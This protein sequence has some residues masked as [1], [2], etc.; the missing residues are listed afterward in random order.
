MDNTM[1]KS[2]GGCSCGSG[3]CTPDVNQENQQVKVQGNKLKKKIVIDFLY[4]D[5]TV[6]ERCQGTENNLDNSVDEVSDVLKS[7]GFGVVVNKI[8]V[9]TKELA[10]KHRFLSSPTIRVNGKDIALELKES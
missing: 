8:N 5:L 3:C 10:I 9:T 4:L 1:G 7:A 2:S 6:C